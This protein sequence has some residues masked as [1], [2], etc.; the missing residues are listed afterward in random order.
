MFGLK[1]LR[2]KRS[3][4]SD[5]FTEGS[6]TSALE[7]TEKKL[8]PKSYLTFGKRL[9]FTIGENSIQM[10][11]AVHRGGKCKL[12]DAQYFEFPTEL[13]NPQSQTEQT[14]SAISAFIDK[15]GGRSPNISISISGRQTAYRSFLMPVL[16][17][18]ELNSSIRFEAQKQLPFPVDNSTFD[19]RCISRF[20]DTER[21]RYR[22]ALFASTLL[23][24]EKQLEPFKA[25]NHNVSEICHTHDAMGQ[26]LHHLPHF[27]EDEVCTLLML[28]RDHCEI[29]FYCGSSLKYFH[30]GSSGTAK[31]ENAITDESILAY[32]AQALI[33][34]I[35]IAH[36]YYTGQYAEPNS[37]SI[38]IYSDAEIPSEL[39]DILSS[40]TAYRFIPFPVSGLDFIRSESNKFRGAIPYCLPAI[41]TATKITVLPNLLPKEVKL[42]L[43]NAL[44]GRRMQ[45][46]LALITLILA[47]S[48]FT[49]TNNIASRRG[50]LYDMQQQVAYLTSSDGFRKHSSLEQ[51]IVLERA[52]IE[53]AKEKPSYFSASLKELSLITPSTIRFIRIEL[54]PLT[55]ERNFI[56]QGIISINETTSG[57]ITSDKMTSEE[58]PPEI[59]LAEFV[60]S[61]N[62][63]SF[64]SNIQ[65]TRHVKHWINDQLEME[66]SIEAGGIS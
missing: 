16:K 22:I 21:Q 28:S 10:V 2:R 31:Y 43:K 27:T 65:I 33:E 4:T 56:I 3:S 1:S 54:D 39:P 61:I 20:A 29:S 48:W 44:F 52:Y 53:K 50:S 35:N 24:V 37:D 17:K 41:A 66:F 46:G 47:T 15:Y 30:I 25:I 32:F 63:S 19:Y 55:P 40:K 14:V 12:L 38:F 11:V 6:K 23:H 7:I 62:A 45:V 5:N 36:D 58:I 64:F 26:L 34:D 60:N 59:I 57:E 18:H 13:S 42:K 8:Y 51:E 9:A 49:M